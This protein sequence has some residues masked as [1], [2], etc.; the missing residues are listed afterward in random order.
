MRTAESVLL[1]C[2]PS[3]P[4]GPVGVDAQVVGVDLDLD[5]VLDLGH[6]LDEGEGGLPALLRV[7]GADAHEPVDATLG[8]QPP[9]GPP[10][11]DGDGRALDAGLL[12]LQLVQDLGL[13]P[14]ALGP[15]QVHAQEH[16]RP[17]G[18]LGAAGAGADGQ[19]RVALVVGSG[20]EEHRALPFVVGAQGVGLGIDLGGQLGVGL[21]ELGD[22]LEIVRSLEQ[23]APE[24]ELLA[25]PIGLA[26][27]ALRFLGVVPEVG[28]A[29]G[30]FEDR[31][32]ARSWS[33][34]QSRPEVARIRS[35]SSRTAAPSTSCA[36]AGPAGGAAAAR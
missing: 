12:A 14:V 13:R 11:V 9:V 5:I 4:G 17:V 35:T 3:R 27:D 26:H 29:G 10:A 18:G 7:V 31:S 25:Q 19:E 20:E 32:G 6:D 23:S 22:L 28:C 34:G 30:L 24:G 2:W 15:A 1:T 33:R 21:G 36:R 8:A 16:L